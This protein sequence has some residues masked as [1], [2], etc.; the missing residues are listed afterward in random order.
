MLS[1]IRSSVFIVMGSY[2]SSSVQT[3]EILVIRMFFKPLS[4]RKSFG[5]YNGEFHDR[6]YLF[7]LDFNRGDQNLY[8][9]DAAFYGNLSHF[10][11][12]RF[13][14]KNIPF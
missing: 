4:D 8:T 13:S 3:L 5:L 14:L 6:T 10:I 9:V 11:N 2:L 12:H 7:D 1:V